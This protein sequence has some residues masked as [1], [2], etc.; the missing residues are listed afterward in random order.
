MTNVWTEHRTAQLKALWA[1][2]MSARQCA[3]KIGNT[4]R[5]AVIGKVGRLGLATR[6]TR[7]RQRP[8]TPRKARAPR[9]AHDQSE[10]KFIGVAE[11]LPLPSE[12]DIPQMLFT[13]RV[14]GQHCAWI[15]GTA[16]PAMCCGDATTAGTHYCQAHL[17]RSQPVCEPRRTRANAQPKVPTYAPAFNRFKAKALPLMDEGVFHE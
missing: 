11:P 14:F 1:D 16:K 8:G 17:V 9:A 13:N 10:P 15:I 4:T 5:N 6:T 12:T 3:M 7:D 2:G